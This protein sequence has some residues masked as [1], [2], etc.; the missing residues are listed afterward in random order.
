M[1]FL[2]QTT[3]RRLLVVCAAFRALASALTA[4]ALAATGGGP[5]P[6][7]KP[8]ARAIHDALAAP[9]VDGVSARIHFTNRL[10][11]QSSLI[12]GSDPVL[13]GGSGRA[14]ASSD[15]R[16]RVEL[17]SDAGAGDSQLLLDH[18][19]FTIFD[20]ATNTVYRGQLPAHGREAD[21][22]HAKVPSVAQI[23]R[24]LAD[25]IQ[26]AGLSGAEPSDVAGRAAYTV[27]ITPKRDGGLLGGAELAWDAANGVPLRAAV[28]EAGSSSPVLELKATDISFGP[29]DSSVFEIHPPADAKVVDLAVPAGGR[30]GAKTVEGVHAVRARVSFPLSAPGRLAGKPRTGVRLASSEGRAGALVTYGRGLGGIIV[31]ESPAGASGRAGSGPTGDLKLQSVSIGGVTGRELPTALGTV[32]SFERAGV[33]YVVAGSVPPSVAEAAARAL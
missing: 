32:I 14:W 12:E 9:A 6:P 29:V 23:E 21:R 13:T 17:Q 31:I 15:G 20:A 33:S 2:R 4:I 30:G 8:L 5:K 26:H 22:A 7:P 1:R 25:L 10:I 18:R 11:D 16:V 27:R 24:R 19:R 28:Y 3:T